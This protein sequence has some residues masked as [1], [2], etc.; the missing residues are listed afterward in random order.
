MNQPLSLPD[1]FSLS[2]LVRL[3]L[4]FLYV[5]LTLPLPFLASMTQAPVS[6]WLLALGLGLGLILL[7]GALAERVILTAEGIQVTYP[8]WVRWILRRGW[9][10][11]WAE[12]QSLKPRSTGQGGLVYYFLS[13]SG[14]GYLLPMR[15]AGFARLVRQVQAHTDLDTSTVRPLS[16]PWMYLILL[17]FTVLLFAMDTWTITQALTLSPFSISPSISP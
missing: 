3:T 12:I 4:L 2:P 15:V 5:S 1:S 9:F 7:Y 8:H 14:Q 6:P 10:L 11:P 16:Q 17:G 13:R